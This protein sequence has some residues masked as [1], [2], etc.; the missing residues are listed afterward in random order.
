MTKKDGQTEYKRGSWFNQSD[1]FKA[2]RE[3]R[4]KIFK[5]LK[6]PSDETDFHF[7]RHERK[8]FRQFAGVVNDV[9]DH[10]IEA[11]EKSDLSDTEKANIQVG[12]TKN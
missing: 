8:T 4:E 2:Q 10:S 5:R 7:S 11:I 1:T 12:K 3:F 9:I 6:S